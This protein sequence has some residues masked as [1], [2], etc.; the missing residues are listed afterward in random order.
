[1]I[2]AQ[3]LKYRSW[4]DG[5]DYELES[6]D[7]HWANY[8]WKLDHFASCIQNSKSSDYVNSRQG[9]F[10]RAI[11]GYEATQDVEYIALRLVNKETNAFGESQGREECAMLIGNEILWNDHDHLRQLVKK[12][13]DDLLDLPSSNLESEGSKTTLAFEVTF[14]KNPE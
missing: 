1:M 8:V 4:K 7:E 13:C 6:K 3:N 12:Y 11:L 14:D 5:L 10:R 9:D 2:D